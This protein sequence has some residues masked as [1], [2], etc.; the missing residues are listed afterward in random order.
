MLEPQINALQ[1]SLTAISEA[2]A[3]ISNADFAEESSRLTRAQILV[4]A[5]TQT[6]QIANQFPQYAASL[7]G[8]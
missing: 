1:D 8:G 3:Q 7:L 5:G 4:Q 6:L 2:E